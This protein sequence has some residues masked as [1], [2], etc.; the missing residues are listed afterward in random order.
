[1]EDI[2]E[3]DVIV[4]SELSFCKNKQSMSCVYIGNPSV[5]GNIWNNLISLQSSL[6]SLLFMIFQELIFK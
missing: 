4:L 6:F 3:K 2:K 1:M 5:K